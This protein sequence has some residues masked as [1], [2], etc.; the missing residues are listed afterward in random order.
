MYEIFQGAEPGYQ[1]K[2]GIE[3]DGEVAYECDFDEEGALLACLVLNQDDSLTWDELE[4]EMKRRGW[5]E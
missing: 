5:K 1:N 2:Y 3:K 4:V